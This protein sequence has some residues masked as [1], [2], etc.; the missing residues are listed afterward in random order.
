MGQWEEALRTGPLRLVRATREGESIGIAGGL[1]LGGLQPVVAMQ[2]TGFF[3]AG[4]ALRNIVHDLHLPLFVIL[5]LRS[6]QAYR[7]GRTTD[8]CPIFV[9]PILCAWR[10]PYVV[11]D[12]QHTAGDI[13]D[14]Y[15]RAW[16]EQKAFVVCLPE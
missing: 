1:L 14:H 13:V 10:L 12:I 9:E 7:S 15:K 16:A 3:E 4:D 6:Y 11:L 8:S 2:C 5:G